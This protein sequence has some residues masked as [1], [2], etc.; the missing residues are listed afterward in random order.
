LKEKIL[1]SKDS[2]L[3]KQ[4]M[5][6]CFQECLGC[7]AQSE[8]KVSAMDWEY[9]NNASILKEG[10]MTQTDELYILEES[11]CC[12]RCC[13]QDG[14]PLTLNVSEGAEKGGAPV[15][16]YTK[17]CG[18]PVMF[19]IHSENG[20]VDCPCCC[21][22]PQMTA[23]T[24]DGRIIS[25]S[26]YICDF[27]LYVPKFMYSENGEDIYKVRPETCCMG[28]CVNC[29]CG[30]KNGC[31]QVPFYFWDPKTEEKIMGNGEGQ[32][33]QILKVFGGL[34]KECCSTADTFA[35]FFPPGI[36]A[37][38][39]AGLLGMTMLVDFVWFEGRQAGE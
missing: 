8:Y 36:T 26:R 1:G 6:G 35:V 28:C 5:K 12:I 37:E 33:P 34:K 32:E 27:C 15:V 39:K 38:R 19:T 4:T 31:V 14:R 7:E 20:D 29:K 16:E 25:N 17:P 22:L 24:P 21:F 13:F 9:M 11:N 2:I 3:V 23:K 30:G 18:C 10:A